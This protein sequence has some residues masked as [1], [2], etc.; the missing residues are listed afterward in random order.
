[1]NGFN[2]FGS[3]VLFLVC[4]F[5]FSNILAQTQGQ[6]KI[7][8]LLTQIK[9]YNSHCNETCL[10]DTIKVILL[11][12][13]AWELKS[14]STDTAIFF[15]TQALNLAKKIRSSFDI[16]KSYIQLASFNYLKS[17]YEIAKEYNYTAIDLLVRLKKDFPNNTNIALMGK[18][19]TAYNNLG[20]IYKEQG[21]YVKAIDLY[22]KGLA[23]NEEMEKIASLSEKEN[24]VKGI[25]RALANIGIVYMEQG[26]FSNALNY[27]FKALTIAEE[28]NWVQLK[29]TLIGNIGNVHNVMALKA[30]QTL[31][32]TKAVTETTI[33][34]KYYLEALEL[35]RQNNDFEGESRHL[36]NIGNNYYL[37]AGIEH[38]HNN[39]KEMEVNY[40]EAIIY[41]LEAKQKDSLMKN[42]NGVARHLGNIGSIYI[43][44]KK[45]KAAEKYLLDAYKI[46]DGLGALNLMKEHLKYLS[47]LYLQIGDYKNAFENYKKSVVIKDSIFNRDKLQ[48]ITKKEMNY[49]FEK[50]QAELKARQDRK[51]VLANAELDRQKMFR[52]SIAGGASILLLFS[53]LIFYYYK[54]NR[55][56]E[57][58]RKEISNSLLISETEMKALQ[59]QMN[60]HFIFNALN[61]I[62]KFLSNHRS[63]ETDTYIKKFQELM[64]FVLENSTLQEV[65]L[66]NDLSALRLYM[67]FERLRLED[68]FMFE[69]NVDENVDQENIM[70]PPLILQPFVENAIWH[71]LQPK[72]EPGYIK[73]SISMENDTISCIVEDNGVGRDMNKPINEFM[74]IKKKSLGM[75]ITEQRL[76]IYSSYKNVKAWFDIIDLQ[77]PE[78]K[79][80]GTRVELYLPLFA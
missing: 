52:N 17:N 4:S 30:M 23:I 33:A 58:R 51:E 63:E 22:F 24:I 36:G 60:P 6:K 13:L 5:L 57:E 42:W 16:G 9:F 19:S 37:R 11:N 55:D 77:N 46:S 80:T 66:K 76:N 69:I 44:M 40:K 74:I 68:H 21:N 32:T 54:R 61:S 41:Y 28:Y 20:L 10:T 70:I 38:Y 26:D 25:G 48:D 8:S 7:D 27:Y 31:D 59:A 39:K 56:S 62:R 79:P 47:D 18:I 3:A 15:S 65:P 43:S 45:F 72:N 1:M 67:E 14:T 49:E 29:G 2:Y 64:R 53:I 75:K 71:G 50:K 34:L 73:I 12:E 78:R 35:A